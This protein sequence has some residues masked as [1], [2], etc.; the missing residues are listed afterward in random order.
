MCTV[1]W[2]L[3]SMDAHHIV[4]YYHAHVLARNFFWPSVYQK[5]CKSLLTIHSK[6]SNY[7]CCYYY[8]Q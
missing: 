5:L 3:F 6:L 8:L 2:P 1:V 7:N 4:K